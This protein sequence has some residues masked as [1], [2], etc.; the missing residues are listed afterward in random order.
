MHLGVRER[1]LYYLSSLPESR[2][3]QLAE[4]SRECCELDRCFSQCEDAACDFHS[5]ILLLRAPNSDYQGEITQWLLC[6]TDVELEEMMEKPSQC[7]QQAFCMSHCAAHCTL[8]QVFGKIGASA[9]LRTGRP[10]RIA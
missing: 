10:S 5:L 9:R 2:L 1:L 3:R 6:R 8:S 4:E 7:P